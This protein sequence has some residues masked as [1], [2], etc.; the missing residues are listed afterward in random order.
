LPLVPTVGVLLALLPA[1]CTPP[2][3]LGNVPQR[4]AQHADAVP[5]APIPATTAPAE[6]DT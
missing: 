5:A 1:W 4:P 3:T 2:P 6:V